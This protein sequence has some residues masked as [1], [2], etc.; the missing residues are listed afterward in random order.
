MKPH[1]SHLVLLV[2]AAW[3]LA[4]HDTVAIAE[5]QSIDPG[6]PTSG[7]VA[8]VD[9]QGVVTLH[10]Y[11]NFQTINAPDLYVIL[12]TLQLSD[13]TNENATEGGVLLGPLES[14]TGAQS[15][16]VPDSVV[17]VRAYTTVLIHCVEFAHLFGGGTLV[18]EVLP[19]VER[20]RS[21]TAAAAT[22]VLRRSVPEFDMLG[23]QLS[24]SVTPNA[25]VRVRASADGRVLLGGSG[26]D[27]R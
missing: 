13:A 26:L 11:E 2:F 5:L 22:S 10:L 27:S 9:D 16:T 21:R 3:A 1:R 20:V 15:F 12:S 7:R 25:A 14:R 24:P 23:R 8:L 18:F 17:S 6:T 19:T 4:S